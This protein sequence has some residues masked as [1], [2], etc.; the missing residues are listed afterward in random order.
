MAGCRH[1]GPPLAGA[2]APVDVS[3]APLPYGA[4]MDGPVSGRR[5]V[6]LV[7][8]LALALAVAG[9]ALAVLIADE[10]GGGRAEDVAPRLLTVTGWR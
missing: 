2:P 5:V 3:R 6:T 7:L 10:A 1:V 9:V 4:G 8:A